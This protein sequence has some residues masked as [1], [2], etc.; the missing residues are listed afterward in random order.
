MTRHPAAEMMIGVGL[1]GLAS[2][3]GVTADAPLHLRRFVDFTTHRP[4]LSEL[5]GF[6]VYR[7]LEGPVDITLFSND[8]GDPLHEID[9]SPSAVVTYFAPVTG[10]SVSFPGTGT[11]NTDYYP[12]GTAI[13]SVD[14][15]LTLVHVPASGSPLL[16]NN[17]RLVFTAV[18]TGTADGVPII[19][20]P[21]E[22]LFVS[23]A[24]KGNALEACRSLGP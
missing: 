21:I 5:C 8:E 12:D 11:L 18:V 20:D 23:G 9:T 22:I 4:E 14:G 24:T 19:S 13:A 2:A 7:R 1:L 10:R 15:I 3:G 17:G 16:I 6:D